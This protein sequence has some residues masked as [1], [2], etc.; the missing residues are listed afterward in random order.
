M[1]VILSSSFI[2]TYVDKNNNCTDFHAL[3]NNLVISVLNY[4]KTVKSFIAR[5]HAIREMLLNAKRVRISPQCV[6]ITP[7]YPPTG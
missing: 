4:Q 2:A 3:K 6:I 1:D 7:I 5:C